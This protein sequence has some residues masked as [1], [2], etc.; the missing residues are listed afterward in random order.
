MPGAKKSRRNYQIGKK[1]RR[2]NYFPESGSLSYTGYYRKMVI[3]RGFR[4]K[5]HSFK[6]TFYP[7]TAAMNINA[8]GGYNP[9]FGELAGP[10]ITDASDM[11]F[12][13]KF[14]L[15]DI[16]QHA[17]FEALFDTYRVNKLVVKFIPQINSFTVIS[18]AGAN[19]A[20][21]AE[22]MATVIDYDDNN[23]LSSYLSALDYETFRE[24]PSYRT[25]K[26][27]YIP[28][29][30]QEVFKTSGTTIGYTQ[31]KKKWIDMAYDDVEFYGL[32][33]VIQNHA[34]TN[35]QQIWRVF[36][37]AYITLKQVR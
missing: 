13:Y 16:P 23:L 36:V 18:T 7:S 2:Y 10:T 11:Y 21:R 32:K 3:P 37:T 31:S 12:S 34:A 17:S 26:R 27:V 9:T 20:N 30:S 22:L 8:V 28:A 15:Q 19:A 1:K 33:G 4:S 24:T 14:L 25:H 5:T 6:Q 29:I 35:I